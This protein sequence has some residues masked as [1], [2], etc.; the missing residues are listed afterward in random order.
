MDDLVP[1]LILLAS[2]LLLA[3]AFL[4][5]GLTMRDAVR[6]RREQ[7]TNVFAGIWIGIAAVVVA[8]QLIHFLAPIDRLVQLLAAAVG[9]LLLVRTVDLE[10]LREHALA[11]AR[12]TRGVLRLAGGAALG[13]FIAYRALG[14][15]VAFD[16]GMY[17]LPAVEWIH[18]SPVVPGLANL[19]G[20]LGFNN[21]A[22]L[23]S[24]LLDGALRPLRAW[25][26]T[27]GFILFLLTMRAW[28]TWSST[29]TR[30]DGPGRTALYDLFL[31]PVIVV[32]ALDPFF[33]SSLT[34]EVPVAAGVFF[35]GRWLMSMS[36]GDDAPGA[37]GGGRGAT[38]SSRA[39]SCCRC[40]S[41]SN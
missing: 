32:L 39:S 9:L 41:R 27:N 2:W 11:P 10:F 5:F 17:H 22:L 29:A 24:A 25:H 1:G 13:L 30:E 6:G 18:A 38:R 14:D 7:P 35:T 16:T 36:D 33:A 20:R 40:W 23:L 34:V 8:L 12:S 28:T 37:V 3:G 4:G 26:V 19:H 21:S 15:P 31:A